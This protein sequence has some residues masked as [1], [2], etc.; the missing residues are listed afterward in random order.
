MPTKFDISVFII[1]VHVGIICLVLIQWLD[2][3]IAY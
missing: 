3:Y 2:T 1:I